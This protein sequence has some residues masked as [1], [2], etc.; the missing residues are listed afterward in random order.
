MRLNFLLIIVTFFFVLFGCDLSKED[1]IHKDDIYQLD[2]IVNDNSYF[3]KKISLVEI[4]KIKIG[5]TIEQVIDILGPGILGDPPPVCLIYMCKDGSRVSVL[6][7]EFQNKGIKYI[8]KVTGI[9]HYSNELKGHFLLPNELKG[10][11]W[12]EIMGEDW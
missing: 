2:D 5:L 11:S 12:D 7:Y 10:K 9:Y 8:G 1:T 4:D 6:F 3:G